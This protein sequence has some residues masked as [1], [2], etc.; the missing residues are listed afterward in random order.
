MAGKKKR[1]ARTMADGKSTSGSL[2]LREHAAKCLQLARTFPPG[3]DADRM[4]RLAL[5]Y[6]QLADRID[7]GI[8]GAAGR[9]R[10]DTLTE[11]EA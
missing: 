4:R 10:G 7:E 5:A 3:E 1:T 6:V 9:R 2:A 8:A 11:P